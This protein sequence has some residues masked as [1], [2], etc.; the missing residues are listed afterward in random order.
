MV[1]D[2]DLQKAIVA[3]ENWINTRSDSSGGPDFDVDGHDLAGSEGLIA[4]LG[5][6]GLFGG[7]IGGRVRCGS[8][9]ASLGFGNAAVGCRP[10]GAGR[11]SP[12]TG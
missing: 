10:P 8:P 6:A 3:H 2:R 11:R 4:L 5:V 12:P 9:E 1:R 7:G